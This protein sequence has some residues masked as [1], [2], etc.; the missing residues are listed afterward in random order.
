MRYRTVHV[1]NVEEYL[2][3]QSGHSLKSVTKWEIISVAPSF[4]KDGKVISWM[5]VFKAEEGTEWIEEAM[6]TLIPS[7]A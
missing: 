1:S 7:D 3:G 5:V 4:F 2:A 6:S